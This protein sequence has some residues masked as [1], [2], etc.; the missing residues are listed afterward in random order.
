MSGVVGR[1]NT[2]SALSVQVPTFALRTACVGAA[3]PM[4]TKFQISVLAVAPN[5]FFSSP[6]PE[7]LIGL[8]CGK[9]LRSAED[10]MPLSL[11]RS[12][13]GQSYGEMRRVQPVLVART[14]PFL[15]LLIFDRPIMARLRCNPHLGTSLNPLGS[16][17]LAPPCRSDVHPAIL[18]VLLREHRRHHLRRG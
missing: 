3:A 14:R 13:Q 2:G 12:G 10:C 6:W 18:A 15:V 4:A 16:A 17:S 1:V 5:C 9:D 8:S 7:L 11:R